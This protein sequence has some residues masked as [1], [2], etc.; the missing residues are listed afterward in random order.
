MGFVL[1]TH[2]SAHANYNSFAT[3]FYFLEAK[4]FST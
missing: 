2:D 1:D 3:L 4:F